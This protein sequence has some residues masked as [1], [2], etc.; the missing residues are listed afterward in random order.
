MFGVLPWG[1]ILGRENCFDA[2]LPIAAAATAAALSADGREQRSASAP[3]SSAGGREFT[4][5]ATMPPEG[6]WLANQQHVHYMDLVQQ[7]NLKARLSKEG[8][9]TDKWGLEPNHGNFIFVGSDQSKWGDETPL[10]YALEQYICQKLTNVPLV[11]FVIQGGPGTLRSV[12]N[13]VASPTKR[14]RMA[15]CAVLVVEDSGG[16]AS[17]LCECI[18]K[19]ELTLDKKRQEM[20]PPPTPSKVMHNSSTSAYDDLIAS[21]MSREAIYEEIYSEVE[22]HC[23][24]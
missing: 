20:S 15:Q 8:Y 11:I 4:R 16:A 10:R 13:A 17:A 21:G 24:V 9:D 23:M 3:V 6:D 1:K 5:S 2:K 18:A 12:H 14:S 19:V 7:T 22:G